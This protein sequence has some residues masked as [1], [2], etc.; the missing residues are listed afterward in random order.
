MKVLS[1]N[2]RYYGGDDGP[3]AWDERRDLCIQVIAMRRPDL[4]CLQECWEEQRRDL[5]GAF[6]DFDHFGAVDEPL[7]RHPVNTVLYRRD[8]LRPVSQGAYWLSKTPHLC[9]SSDWDSA[10]VRLA[11]WV[12][13]EE[14]ASGRQLRLVNTH[15][16]HVS[17]KARENQAR[18]IN[19]E[20]ASWPEEYPQILCGDM[21][22]DTAN[23]AIDLLR[24]GG[25]RDTYAAV[26]GEGE[27]GHTF[28]GFL[29]PNYDARIGKM[30]WV[31]CRGDIEATDAEIIRDDDGGRLPSDHYF[32]G[33][34]LRFT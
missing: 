9:G 5:V 33:A 14:R 19:H 26:Y 4:I 25:W 32:V 21:N 8:V 7:G 31:F 3:N 20:A 23:K 28:H 16:D 13:L 27:P 11:T 1:C 29:G 34:D 17:Q 15:L 12:R 10:C 30:D 6:T 22:C 2:I 18:V 24:R